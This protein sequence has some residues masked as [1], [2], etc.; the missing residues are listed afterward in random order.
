MWTREQL[1]EP[2]SKVAGGVRV[3]VPQP[4]AWM[5]ERVEAPLVGAGLVAPGF[6]DSIALNQYHDGSEG[7]QVRGGGRERLGGWQPSILP[8]ALH[9]CLHRHACGYSSLLSW[10]TSFIHFAF[11]EPL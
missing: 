11:A 5:R 7:I 8:P 9:A 2:D 1:S 3:D 4:P 10:P 6:V